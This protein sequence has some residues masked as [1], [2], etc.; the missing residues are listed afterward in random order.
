M[1]LSVLSFS[2][3]GVSA[4]ESSS[5]SSFVAFFFAFPFGEAGISA[6][7]RTAVAFA[8]MMPALVFLPL[9]P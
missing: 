2:A 9:P 6:P 5:L 1:L 4:V 7:L 3:G 8:L